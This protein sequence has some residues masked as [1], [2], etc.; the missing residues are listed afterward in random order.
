MWSE[1]KSN[2]LRKGK[3][4]LIRSEPIYPKH[5]VGKQQKGPDRHFREGKGKERVG[6]IFRKVQGWWFILLD[7]LNF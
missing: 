1:E 4:R 7:Y 5:R 3:F 6:G 2:T